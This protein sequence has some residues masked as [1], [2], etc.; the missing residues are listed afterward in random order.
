MYTHPP[1]PEPKLKRIIT[2]DIMLQISQ[3]GSTGMLSHFPNSLYSPVIIPYI[4]GFS[5]AL[6]SAGADL[7]QRLQEDSSGG[8]SGAVHT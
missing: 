4:I 3:W 6:G 8:Y 5:L 2:S 7:L 1:P